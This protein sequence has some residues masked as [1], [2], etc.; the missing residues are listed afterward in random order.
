MS[1]D[2][3]L[4]IEDLTVT[5]GT[6]RGAARAVAGVTWTV[7][8]G[9]TLALVGESGSGKSMSVLAATGLT[10]RAARVSGSVRLLDDPVLLGQLR[11]LERRTRAGGHDR[12]GHR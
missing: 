5:F 2:P 11:G 7:A 4:S 6:R 1:T 8:K 10:P 9:E 12:V 3:V